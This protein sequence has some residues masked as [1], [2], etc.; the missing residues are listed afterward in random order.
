M[1]DFNKSD[2]AT[3]CRNMRKAQRRW[4]MV[5]KVMTKTGETVRPWTMMY[6]VVVHTVLMYRIDSWVVLDEMLKVLEGFH[7]WVTR[8]I[9]G[10]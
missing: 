10:M 6:K 8:R 5:V 1:L 7:H 3:M 4:G 9:S 2:W